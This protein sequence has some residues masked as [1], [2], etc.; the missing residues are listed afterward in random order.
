M[1]T[2]ACSNNVLYVNNSISDWVYLDPT[3]SHN[4]NHKACLI[5]YSHLVPPPPPPPPQPH[6]MADISY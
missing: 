3:P 1:S 2:T 4:K 6:L 5:Q